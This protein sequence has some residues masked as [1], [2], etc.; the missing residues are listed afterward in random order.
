MLIVWLAVAEAPV[1]SITLAVTDILLTAAVGVPL[2]APV[3]AFRLN[4]AGRAL[5]ENV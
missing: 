1:E 5:I 3:A 4:P 2:I